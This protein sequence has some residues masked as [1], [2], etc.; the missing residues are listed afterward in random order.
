MKSRTLASIVVGLYINECTD[1]VLE[2]PR[3]SKPCEQ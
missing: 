1:C 3:G 2:F